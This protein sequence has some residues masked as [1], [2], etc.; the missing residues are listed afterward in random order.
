NWLDYL[1]KKDNGSIEIRIVGFAD[2]RGMFKEARYVEESISDKDFTFL[3][4]QE[5]PIDNTLL[6][7]LRAYQTGLNLKKR[8]SSLPIYNSLKKRIMW[9]AEG[10]GVYEGN[11]KELMKR[12]VVIVINL[13]K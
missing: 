4:N 8:I 9:T 3:L 6:S 2:Q 7:R 1:A 13:A 11:I 12:K 10:R 5:A